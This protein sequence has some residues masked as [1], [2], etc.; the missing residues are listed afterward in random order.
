MR[1]LPKKLWKEEFKYYSDMPLDILRDNIVLLTDQRV[2]A[3]SNLNLK[4]IFISDYEFVITP[5]W[6][7]SILRGYEQNKSN[8]Y[9]EGKIVDD[10]NLTTIHFTVRP[11]IGFVILLLTCFLIGILLLTIFVLNYKFTEWND[12]LNA[13]IA[14]TLITPFV[15]YIVIGYLKK[16]IRKRF[17][18]TFK[19]KTEGF[20]IEL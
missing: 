3:Q 16:A 2:S 17:V 4:G 18:S 13:A 10:N 9:L 7:Y 12:L 14:Y 1:L 5:K 15:I 8:S 20:N 19:L 6:Q 11:N